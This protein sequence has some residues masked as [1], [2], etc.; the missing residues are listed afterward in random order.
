MA[1]RARLVRALAVAACL[2]A[3]LP[4][5]PPA[6][7]QGSAHTDVHVVA[8]RV[9]RPASGELEPVSGLWVVL[10]R[11]GSDRAGPLD[12]MLTGTRGAYEFRYQ[13]F[14]DE[15]ALYFAAASYGGVAYFTPPLADVV[16][17]EPA[18][19]IVYD[20]TTR[21]IPITVRGRHVVVSA[22][23]PDA[24]RTVLEVYE[25]SNDTTL[26]RV[27][28]ASTS[29]PTW[30]AGLP[31]AARSPRVSD[32]DIPPDAVTFQNDEVRVVAPLPPGVKQ[33]AFT[34]SMPATAFPLSVPLTAAADILE[35]LVEDPAGAARGASLDETDPVVVDG[36]RFR[37]FLAQEVQAGQVAIV[38]VPR[39]ES[40]WRSRYVIGIMLLVGSVMFIAL[41]HVFRRT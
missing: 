35:V 8:G 23:D 2:T 29:P 14:G 27:S 41:A 1:G 4:F 25:L 6:A 36:R 31:A 30:R 19:I 13:P 18:E 5:A 11:L 33:L 9:L 21:D 10:H 3:V 37:R 40:S 20:T 39:A 24:M 7:A 26:T 28:P 15:R 12:S 16:R 17:G 38:D 22:A 32:G 34:Y